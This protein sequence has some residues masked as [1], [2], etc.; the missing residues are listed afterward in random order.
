MLSSVSISSPLSSEASP[1]A[2]EEPWVGH[3]PTDCYVHLLD[4]LWVWELLWDDLPRLLLRW[5]LERE[6][7]AGGV[8]LMDGWNPTWCSL[9]RWIHGVWCI[10]HRSSKPLAPDSLKIFWSSCCHLIPYLCEA[11][12]VPDLYCWTL[13]CRTFIHRH[14]Q[15]PQSLK[16]PFL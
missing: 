16:G 15:K 5:L 7:L 10:V 11:K 14:M 13:I 9:A 3:A 12:R 4:L 2:F 1:C 6:T 8:G